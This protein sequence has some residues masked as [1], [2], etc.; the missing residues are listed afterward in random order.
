MLRSLGIKIPEI[1]LKEELVRF[2][3]ETKSERIVEIPLVLSNLPTNKATILDVG[4]RYSLL[5]I[6]LASLGHRVMA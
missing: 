4:C 2:L 1:G 6:Q 3:V 5:S